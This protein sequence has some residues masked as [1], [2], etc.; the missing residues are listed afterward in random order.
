MVDAR[1]LARM[2]DGGLLVNVAR[3]A[4]VETAALVPEVL[5]GRLRAALDV[6]E[7]EPL[8]PGHPLWTAPGVLLTPHVGGDS[9]AFLPRARRL[10][11]DQL[12]RLAAGQP[13][14]HVVTSR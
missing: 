12:R 1:F 7:P 4:V 11:V 6:T 3:G 9:T 14:H 8:P 5:A 10:I 2:R 13:P